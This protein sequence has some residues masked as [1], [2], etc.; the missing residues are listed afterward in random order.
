M[1]NKKQLSTLVFICL[2]L[3]TAMPAMAEEWTPISGKDEL[4]RL[5]SGLKAERILPGGEVHRGEYLPDGTGTLFAWGAEIPRTWSVKGN[6]QVCITAKKA[7][8][9]YQL[10]RSNADPQRFRARELSS[11]TIA[12]FEMTK[13]GLAVVKAAPGETGNKGGATAPSA[14]EVAAELSNPNTSVASLT[15]RSQFRWFEGDLPD[16]DDQSSF[17]MLFQPSLPFVLDSG[18]KVLWRPAVPLFF[19]KPVFDVSTAGFEG[20]AGLGDIAF[21]LAYAPK[22]WSHLMFAY[23]LITSLPTATSSDLGTGMWTLG[24]EVLIGKV[25]PWGIYGALTN[26][27]WDVTGWGDVDINLTSISAFFVYL[28]GG[29]YNVGSA[30]IITYDWEN[31]QWTVPLQINAGKTVMFGGRPWKLSVELNYYVEKPDAFAPEWMLSLNVTPVVKN[32][33]AGWFGLGE[34]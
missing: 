30:P 16:A 12:E 21:D 28:P 33:L 13:S 25:H 8:I 31:E 19:N 17:M 24:P 6:D 23:G 22:K 34:K 29:G 4:N 2:L 27:Q 1:S 32:G 18:D 7:I 5:M 26:H 9:C 11:G 14:D 3:L 15:L 10:E 20:E